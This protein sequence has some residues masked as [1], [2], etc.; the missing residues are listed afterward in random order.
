M[1][2][3]TPFPVLP[4]MSHIQSIEDLFAIET[5]INRIAFVLLSKISTNGGGMVFIMGLFVFAFF[6][7]FC[8]SG[9]SIIDYPFGFSNVYLMP[10]STKFQIYRG[11]VC[12]SLLSYVP[13]V[14]SFSVFFILDCPLGY[15]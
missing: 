3:K 10:L 15:H 5:K 12:L 1:K 11:F 4:A 2:D 8:L 9:F 7:L 14:T 13:N 6:L